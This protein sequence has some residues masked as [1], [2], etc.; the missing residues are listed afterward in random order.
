[1]ST[2]TLT[3]ATGS[4]WHEAALC[5][6]FRTTTT[7]EPFASARRA[8]GAAWTVGNACSHIGASQ[9]MRGP[10]QDRSG[11]VGGLGLS[12]ATLQPSTSC[13]GRRSHVSATVTGSTFTK[14]TPD[15]AHSRQAQTCWRSPS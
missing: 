11:C 15:G 2:T 7:S 14:A 3:L 4:P 8:S 12:A 10:R 6:P 9:V 13:H 1:M 5:G